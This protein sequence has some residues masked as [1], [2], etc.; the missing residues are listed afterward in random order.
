VAKICTVHNPYLRR[1]RRQLSGVFTNSVGNFYVPTMER[2][3]SLLNAYNM[4][5]IIDQPRSMASVISETRAFH[6]TPLDAPKC[7]RIITELLYHIGQGDTVGETEQNDLFF[8]FMKLFQS[9]NTRLRRMVYLLLKDISDG[10]S[11][12]FMVTN[13]LSKDMQSK[14]DCYRAN[15]IRVSRILDSG[16]VSQIDRYLKTAVV[17]K[18]PFVASA[19][20]VCGLALCNNVPDMIRRWV[21][22]VGEALTSKN[23]MVQY[24]ALSLTHELRRQDRLGLQ[25]LICGFATGQQG[26]PVGSRG[27]ATECLLIGFA[28]DLI[29]TDREPQIDRVLLGYLE[30]CLRNKSDV[31]TFEASRALC[32]LAQIETDTSGSRRINF[33]IPIVMGLDFAHALTVLQICLGSSKP[34]NRLAA[35]RV[36]NSLSRSRPLVVAKC[37]QDIE[38]LL[39]DQNRNIA[40]MALTVLLKTAQEANV[41]KLVKQIGSFMND[42]TDIYKKDVVLAVRNLCEAY[43][44]KYK[45]LLNFL[46]LA[47]RDEGSHDVKFAICDAIIFV[48]KSNPAALESGLLHL[49]EFIE[50]C[51]FPNLCCSVMAFLAEHVPKTTSPSQY[52]RFIYNRLILENATVRVA[53]V[54]ALA[55]IALKTEPTLAN[56]IHV[57][58]QTAVSDTD[59]EV[60]DRVGLYLDLLRPDGSTT[61]SESGRSELESILNEEPPFSLDALCEALA[62]HVND[63]SRMDVEFDVSLVPD[64]ATYVAELRARE[65]EAMAA[66]AASEQT[67]A[68]PTRQRAPSGS[69][70]AIPATTNTPTTASEEFLAAVS[71]IIDPTRLG[72][73]QHVCKPQLLTESEA[74]YTVR[75]I[76]HVFGHHT[77]IEFC[78][79]NT[80]ENVVLA[81]VQVKLSNVDPN[82]FA[83]IGSL[84]APLIGIG[85][86]KS[87]YTVFARRQLAPIGAF[88]T[89]LHFMQREDGDPVGFPDDF[90]IEP[91]RITK[92]DY[93]VGRPLPAGQF[94]RAW[95]ALGAIERVQKYALSYKTLEATVNGLI[96]TLNL[97]PCEGTDRLEAGV[98]KPTLLL[99]GNAAGNVPVLAQA[100]LYIHPQRGCMIQL[101]SRAGSDEA[102]EMVQRALE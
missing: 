42:L 86:G 17:D 8:A 98:Q 41:E 61:G 29:L 101:T 59:D 39:V 67:R 66:Q 95:D 88:P 85:E 40:T 60:R 44:A 50:D 11:S 87:A 21:N 64:Q 83:E 96:Q 82:S 4:T 22:E 78:V 89:S 54:E 13:C 5:S 99:A 37:N 46:A 27:I 10:S 57:L 35:L 65:A 14:N 84:A 31:V 75:A 43:P 24:H 47:L 92:G 69:S 36:L 6:E 7:C 34:V 30:S 45:A 93:L 18:S 100:I 48:M 77:V 28:L 81:N 102:A 3:Q 73:L 15:A 68:G 91:L 79:T 56:N 16:T 25:K 63:P 70:G 2:I 19:A 9:Q 26:G 80:V 12:V 53:A 94:P 33:D 32:K 58:L 62:E 72:P 1:F 55:R 76:K 97:A 90:P 51:E 52:I 38:P 23:Q 49:C 71:A 20:L 74:E